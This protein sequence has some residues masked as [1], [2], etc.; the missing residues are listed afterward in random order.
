MSFLVFDIE[1]IPDRELWKP[2]EA[3]KKRGAKADDTPFA[4]HYAHVPIAIGT[5]CSL[6]SWSC[7]RWAWQARRH[8]ARTRRH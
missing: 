1:T 5:R 3:P 2:E 6:M 7:R 4:P 8:S